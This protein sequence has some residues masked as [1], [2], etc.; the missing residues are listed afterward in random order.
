MD[1]VHNKVSNWDLTL[2]FYLVGTLHTA[3]K[4][5]SKYTSVTATPK[6]NF[7]LSSQL[8]TKIILGLNFPFDVIHGDD[9]KRKIYFNFFLSNFIAQQTLKKTR[10]AMAQMAE[11]RLL[12]W[13]TR[14]RIL[15]FLVPMRSHF[16]V[17]AIWSASTHSNK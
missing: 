6:R 1:P 3:P 2:L 15:P 4:H 17:E 5:W 8:K 7:F 12:I 9:L 10:D 14:V 13:H 16:S 11:R